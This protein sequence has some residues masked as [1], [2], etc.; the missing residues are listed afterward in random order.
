MKV[1]RHQVATR[2]DDGACCRRRLPRSE[3]RANS[4]PGTES[5]WR[6]ELIGGVLLLQCMET[7]DGVS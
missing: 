4:G 1:E 3:E 7:S 6:R 2:Q 5:W